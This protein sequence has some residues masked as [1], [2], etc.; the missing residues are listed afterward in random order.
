M[1]GD[2]TLVGCSDAGRAVDLDQL[3]LS[4]TI[5]SPANNPTSAIFFIMVTSAPAERGIEADGIAR[6]THA[7]WG[8]GQQAGRQDAGT[9]SRWRGRGIPVVFCWGW[10]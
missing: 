8:G 4:E 2:S 6:P 9:A 1:T 3:G 7:R 5:E 10:P